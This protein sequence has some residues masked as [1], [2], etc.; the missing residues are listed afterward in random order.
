MYAVCVDGR[1]GDDFVEFQWLI[2]HMCFWSFLLVLQNSALKSVIF[3]QG[4]FLIH[5]KYIVL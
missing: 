2:L 3:R 5:G 4:N 1:E